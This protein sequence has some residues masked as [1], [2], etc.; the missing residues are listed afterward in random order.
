MAIPW[1]KRCYLL[2]NTRKENQNTKTSYLQLLS[3]SRVPL[4]RSSHCLR[5]SNALFKLRIRWKQ[6]CI[7]DS[8]VVGF[9]AISHTVCD[10]FPFG[11]TRKV[12]PFRSGSV[13]QWGWNGFRWIDFKDLFSITV[14]SKTCISYLK[15]NEQL[16]RTRRTTQCAQCSVPC[17][18]MRN[19]I[20]QGNWAVDRQNSQCNLCAEFW[21]VGVT[22]LYSQHQRIRKRIFYYNW[23]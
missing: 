3:I 14:K 19:D 1:V 20:A 22:V 2:C 16:Y 12:P 17:T 10:C 13:L 5:F 4:S 15:K 11:V 8:I 18:K 23:V 21:A 7:W 6:H 9:P